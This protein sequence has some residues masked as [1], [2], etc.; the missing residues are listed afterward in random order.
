MNSTVSSPVYDPG[1]HKTSA[2]PSSRIDSPSI[3]LPNTT[4]L[5]CSIPSFFEKI[6]EETVNAS[7][8]LTRTTATP[9]EPGAV[10]I[11]QIVE[12]SRALGIEFFTT[13]I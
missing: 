12:P 10:E 11:A 8:P 4:P 9:P 13:Q 2:R 7:E 6:E 1:P 5:S 3:I